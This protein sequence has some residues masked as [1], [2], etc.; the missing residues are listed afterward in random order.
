MTL[1][2]LFMF[3]DQKA[4]EFRA[5]FFNLLNHV[6][7]AN[8]VLNADNG[9]MSIFRSLTPAGSSRRWGTPGLCSS[10]SSSGF[11]VDVGLMRRIWI[12]CVVLPVLATGAFAQR[13]EP[14]SVL[15][16]NVQPLQRFGARRQRRRFGSRRNG[17]VERNIPSLPAAPKPKRRRWRRTPNGIQND[18]SPTC[19]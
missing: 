7:F 4:V 12:A 5:E 2:K 6:N 11:E 1:A 9:P 19:V 14:D 8:P 18:A 17:Q 3:G 16:K 15:V 13:G 10:R